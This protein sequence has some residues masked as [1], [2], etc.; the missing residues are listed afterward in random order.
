MLA[1]L[2]LTGNAWQCYLRDGN[3]VHAISETAMLS[4]IG[5]AGNANSG[6]S[7]ASQCYLHFPTDFPIGPNHTV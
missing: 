6:D 1:M 7:I 3:A 4:L 2:S 5:N